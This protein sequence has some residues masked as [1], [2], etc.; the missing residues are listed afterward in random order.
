MNRRAY[1]IKAEDY[2]H[3]VFKHICAADTIG[4]LKEAEKKALDD[5]VP[6]F[7]IA[8]ML[9]WGAGNG[10]SPPPP[11]QI[12][13]KNAE[14]EALMKELEKPVVFIAPQLP[15]DQVLVHLRNFRSNY[16][17]LS[18]QEFLETRQGLYPNQ[19]HLIEQVLNENGLQYPENEPAPKPVVE[20][21]PPTLATEIPEPE[22]PPE[23]IIEA[24]TKKKRKP[25]EQLYGKRQNNKEIGKALIVDF[26]NADRNRRRKG[27]KIST[28]YHTVTW[29]H[30][31]DERTARRYLDELYKEG[32]VKRWKEPVI[33]EGGQKVYH[34]WYAS[35]SMP[36]EKYHV[37]IDKSKCK[38]T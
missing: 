34:H 38:K 5:G 4:G 36:N 9:D 16:P 23:A 19:L 8:K 25:P 27:Y 15:D 35:T 37:W 20:T 12:Q 17:H 21:L 18:A 3:T 13:Q 10:T 24:P 1:R 11:K 26:L 28:I 22:D 33:L 6:V 7:E 14:A 29:I 32:K 30:T 31:I 2:W